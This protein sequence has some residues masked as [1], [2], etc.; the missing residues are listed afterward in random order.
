MTDLEERIEAAFLELIEPMAEFCMWIYQNQHE[1]Q[2]GTLDYI[3][4]DFFPSRF[5][6]LIDEDLI[7]MINDNRVD[8]P[9]ASPEQIVEMIFEGVRGA[10]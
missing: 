9:C 2:L 10:A 8:F 1:M 6:E 4:A 3:D 5:Q 7:D